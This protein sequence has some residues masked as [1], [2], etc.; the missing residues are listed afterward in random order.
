MDE[1]E[2]MWFNDDEDDFESSQSDSSANGSVTQTSQSGGDATKIKSC[3]VSLKLCP[4]QNGP[5]D[6]D[7]H[8][9]DAKSSPKKASDSTGMYTIY[10]AE[11]PLNRPFCKQF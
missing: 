6:S 1:D 11:S 8:D 4:S 9:G 7:A 5:A 3:F 10:V 2:E